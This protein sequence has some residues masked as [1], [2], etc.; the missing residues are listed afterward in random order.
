MKE[1]DKFRKI[2]FI[3][4]ADNGGTFRMNCRKSQYLISATVCSSSRALLKLRELFDA[5]ADVSLLD[6]IL[7]VHLDD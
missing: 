2:V 5:A 6:N 1:C 4:C 3:F 7:V